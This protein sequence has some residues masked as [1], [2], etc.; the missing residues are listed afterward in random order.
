MSELQFWDTQRWMWLHTVCTSVLC[1]TA[2]VLCGGKGEEPVIEFDMF[3][4]V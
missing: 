2:V 1:Y 4:L 3:K